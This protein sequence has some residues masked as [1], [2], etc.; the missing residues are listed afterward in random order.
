[1]ATQFGDGDP[2]ASHLGR[3]PRIY[4][5][6]MHPDASD[7]W[8]IIGT[9]AVNAARKLTPYRRGAPGSVSRRRRQ[10]RASALIG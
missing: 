7:R 8:S 1:M 4:S 3:F 9:V 10:S 5:R 6:H 2:T